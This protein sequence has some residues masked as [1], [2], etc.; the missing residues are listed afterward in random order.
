[1]CGGR[2]EEN[3]I[4]LESIITTCMY[5]FPVLT[6]SS[7]IFPSFLV[8]SITPLPPSLALSSI[9]YSISL[10]LSFNILPLIIFKRRLSFPCAPSVLLSL[11]FPPLRLPSCF[12]S[13]SFSYFL[14]GLCAPALSFISISSGRRREW[15]P[16]P[17]A[18]QERGRQGRG[19]KDESQSP[20]FTL[21]V[22]QR[23]GTAVHWET[24]AVCSTGLHLAH[25]NQAA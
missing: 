5:L 11:S 14:R 25:F 9:S 24:G 19:R 22:V 18:R 15:L 6:S 2:Q 10:S 3:L 13:P 12:P 1:M 23:S 17:S 16:W 4:T 20:C 8:H 7:I 21:R